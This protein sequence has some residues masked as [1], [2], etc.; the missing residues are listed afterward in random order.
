MLACCRIICLLNRWNGRVQWFGSWWTLKAAVIHRSLIA[1]RSP[2]STA[3]SMR[4]ISLRSTT[5]PSRWSENCIGTVTT[6]HSVNH[7]RQCCWKPPLTVSSRRQQWTD[8]SEKFPIRRR[9]LWKCFRATTAV[10]TPTE[11]WPTTTGTTRSRP[12]WPP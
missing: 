5:S 9:S 7:L 4:K 10:L 12:W 6:R 1:A 3:T 8:G 11:W 2:W